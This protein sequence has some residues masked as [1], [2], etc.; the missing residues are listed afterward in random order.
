M[1]G[2]DATQITTFSLDAHGATALFNEAADKLAATTL[3]W[4]HDEILVTPSPRLLALDRKSRTLK[5]PDADE[6]GEQKEG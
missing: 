2:S 6:S 5:Q 3:G 4:H 1:L